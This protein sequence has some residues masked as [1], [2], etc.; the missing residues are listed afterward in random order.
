MAVNRAGV[1]LHHSHKLNMKILGEFK[2]NNE[3]LV[4]PMVGSRTSLFIKGDECDATGVHQPVGKIVFHN[5][6]ILVM[7]V[8]GHN[9]WSGRGMTSYAPAEFQTYDMSRAER[10][11]NGSGTTVVYRNCYSVGAW[12]V[13]GHEQHSAI[14][15]CGECSGR[16]E[17]WRESRDI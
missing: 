9:Y 4:T 2:L 8:K 1:H 15:K 10:H 13:R 11:P 3:E 5:R 14:D 7:K 16:A 12:D 6:N 17:E